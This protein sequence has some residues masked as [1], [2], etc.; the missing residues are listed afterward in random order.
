[1][2]DE[3]LIRSN[4]FIIMARESVNMLETIAKSP[5][6]RNYDDGRFQMLDKG[7]AMEISST[8]IREEFSRGGE[9]RYLLPESCY[10]YIKEHKLYQGDDSE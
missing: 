8:Y 5:L 3:Q 4:K 6:L 7:L 1:M 10:N 9:P 2:L